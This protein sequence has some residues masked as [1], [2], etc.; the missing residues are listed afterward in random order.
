MEPL[1]EGL[2]TTLMGKVFSYMLVKELLPADTAPGVVSRLWG[3]ERERDRGG[4]A[5]D[6]LG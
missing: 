5:F 2:C 6:T 4:L 3:R 1:W